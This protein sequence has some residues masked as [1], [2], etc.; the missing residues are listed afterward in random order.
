PVTAVADP[1][2]RALLPGLCARLD[3]LR[4]LTDR[5]LAAAGQAET[6]TELDR[7]YDTAF[8]DA[9]GLAAAAKEHVRRLEDRDRKQIQGIIGGQIGLLIALACAGVLVARWRRRQLD[10]LDRRQQLI[11]ESASEAVFGL[12][13]RGRV[14]FANPAAERMTGFHSDE[15]LGSLLHDLVHHRRSDGSPYPAEQCPAMTSLHGDAVQQVTGE[16]FWRKDGSSFPVEYSCTPIRED[17]GVVGAVHVVRDVTERRAAQRAKDEFVAVVSHELRTPL[18]SIHGALG[19]LRAGVLGSLS[20]RGQRMVDIA[21]SNTD[22]LVRLIND[23]LDVERLQAGKAALHKQACDAAEL[24]SRCAEAMR[25]MA[26]EAGVCLVTAVEPA[27][28][29]ADSDRIEQTLTNLI[30]N[31]VKF[32]PPGTTVRLLTIREEQAVRFEV[33]DEGRGIPPDKL[34]GVFG[35]FQ[36]VDASDSREKGGSGLGLAICRN[37]VEQHGGRIWVDSSPGRGATFA[38]TL[39]VLADTSELATSSSGPTVLVCDDDPSVREVVTTV[40]AAEGFRVLATASGPEAVNEA[41]SQRP[42]AIVL[43]ML[44]PG[45]DGWA[46]A[47]AL[48]ERPETRDTPIVVVS[49]L[50]RRHPERLRCDVAEWIEK[51]FNTAELLAALWRV[52]GGARGA[53]RLLVVEDDEGLAGVLVAMFERHGME[54]LHA[55]SGAE[56]L[57][58]CGRAVPDL[59][60]LDLLLPDADGFT[61]VER[62]RRIDRFRHLPV[63][64]YTAK[65][66]DEGERERLRLADTVVYTKSRVSLDD[67]ERRVVALLGELTRQHAE[68][69]SR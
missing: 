35:R 9:L 6:G 59:V 26:D 21:A 32:S 17:G 19:L 65:E 29:W 1:A 22:R 38:F 40:L 49:A 23:I 66:I 39:P 42:A 68:Q 14:S 44:M 53:P 12:D 47:A 11:L 24:V 52:V 27:T 5:R 30:S 20:E 10:R 56:A 67:L 48:K 25:P 43:D 3:E 45:M 54:V 55:R 50:P 37:I 31:A 46:T 34:Q 60:I 62:L 63:V 13:E 51:P 16:V 18:T 15:L 33:V 69:A 64:V 36:Q 58:L 28:V 7:A 8:S 2:L 61:I 4:D 57:R 41:I